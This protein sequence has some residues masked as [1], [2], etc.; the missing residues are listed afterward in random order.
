MQNFFFSQL[1]RF[2]HNPSASWLANALHR[3][4][5]GAGRTRQDALLSISGFC[6]HSSLCVTSEQVG[7]DMELADQE[8][9]AAEQELQVRL[10]AVEQQYDC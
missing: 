2:Q 3:L 6:S 10:V 1:Y 9:W 8:R 7:C 5:H 4:D